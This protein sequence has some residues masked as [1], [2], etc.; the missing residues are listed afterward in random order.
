[1]IYADLFS[2]PMCQDTGSLVFYIDFP[3]GDAEKKYRDAI[4]WAAKEATANNICAPM[5]WIRL[6]LKIQAII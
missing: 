2:T 4:E 1:M 5:R 6:P 3:V